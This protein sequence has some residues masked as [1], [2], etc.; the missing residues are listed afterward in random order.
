MHDS[1]RRWVLRLATALAAMA[2][3]AIASSAARAQGSTV[4]QNGTVIA[5]HIAKFVTNGR[6]ADAGGLSGDTAGQG[7]APLAITDGKALGLCLNSALTTGAYNA[8]CFGHDSDSN[9]LIAI[10]SQ[11]GLADKAL[12]IRLNGTTYDFPGPGN[13]NVLGPTP[14]PP[15]GNIAL[16]NGGQ[17]LKDGGPPIPPSCAVAEGIGLVGD[18]ATDNKA[19]WDAYMAA[20]GTKGICVSLRMNASYYF[21]AA[22]ATLTLGPQQAFYLYGNRAKLVFNNSN[23]LSFNYTPSSGLGFGGSRLSINDTDF[24]TNAQGKTGL[25]INGN[26]QGN[27][28]VAPTY[29]NRN[30]YYG[31]DQSVS[32]Y[33]G[34]A[35]SFTQASLLFVNGESVTGKVAAYLGTGLYIT[36]TSPTVTP[37]AASV[38][39][40]QDFWLAKGIHV[41]RYFQGLNVAGG[42]NFVGLAEGVVCDQS[43]AAT[44]EYQC[45]VRDS[46]F[47][48]TTSAIRINN[49][50]DST[51]QGNDIAGGVYNGTPTGTPGL[52]ALSGTNNT[53][54]II[55]GN[56]I[57]A[58]NSGNGNWNS[59][60]TL[61]G[62][63]TGNAIINNNHM[64]CNHKDVV[65]TG[66]PQGV[67]VM[68]NRRGGG[69][70][71]V[72]GLAA[73]FII[74]DS[75]GMWI[76]AGNNSD[77]DLAWNGHIGP[78]DPT[79]LPTLACGT[80][81][82]LESGGDAGGTIV[83]T[84]AGAS[85]QLTFARAHT[86][87]NSC[88]VTPHNTSPVPHFNYSP[89]LTGFT[90][91]WP[92]DGSQSPALSY[93]CFGN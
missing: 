59:C 34:I 14:A 11:G 55:T 50:V 23:G 24:V 5:N 56:H 78:R 90:A 1:P 45:D 10:D 7:L 33:W 46:S 41:D 3:M 13:G 38:L 26:I 80:G 29:L 64:V 6:I 36:G 53:N 75:S 20:Q 63:G 39:G 73:P 47:N 19:V 81:A 68:G 88:V 83:M 84:T 37:S 72:V 40:E 93:V 27:Q 9:A 44:P 67:T 54:T 31:L 4:Y 52:I 2:A 71:D 25:A 87:Y 15:S 79:V 49:W 12:K 62:A 85:C 61:N 30:H 60:V 8:F 51:I 22:P 86:N 16:W 77:G 17:T 69:G 43:D 57:I 18:G 74:A 58:Y 66:S 42:S 89:T 28:L 70:Q 92:G 48:V 32:Q 91:A 65:A 82:Y 76:S 21:S 35:R